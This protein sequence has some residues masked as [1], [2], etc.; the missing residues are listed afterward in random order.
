MPLRR[1]RRFI[2]AAISGSAGLWPAM[3]T[4]KRPQRRPLA[5]QPIR[6]K[7]PRVG[8]QARVGM[9]EEQ[10]VRVAGARACVH[11]G[12]AAARRGQDEIGMRRGARARV[13]ARAAVD[14]DDARARRPK[15]AERGEM[16]GDRILLVQNRHDDGERHGATLA[17]ARPR[18]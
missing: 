11:L 9:E 6:D 5:G 7:P 15:A 3:S 16:G 8:R 18:L 13:V 1:E 17:S 4:S 14:D 12:G 10:D 2:S